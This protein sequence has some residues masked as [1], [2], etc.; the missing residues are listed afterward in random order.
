MSLVDLTGKSFPDLPHTPANDQR[1]DAIIV[2]AN[3][4]ETSHIGLIHKK[5]LVFIC[6]LIVMTTVALATFIKFK[7][8]KNM[9]SKL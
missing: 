5:L 3:Q 6:N 9:R 7:D 2:V 1:Y 4:N 8:C